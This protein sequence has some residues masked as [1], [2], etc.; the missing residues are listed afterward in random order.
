MYKNH[1]CRRV[2]T[3]EWVGQTGYDLV[4]PIVLDSPSITDSGLVGL[5]TVC[6]RSGIVPPPGCEAILIEILQ[7]K[8]SAAGP[9]FSCCFLINL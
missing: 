7:L 2:K 1:L 6:R 3:W 5:W 4:L 8:R 9:H